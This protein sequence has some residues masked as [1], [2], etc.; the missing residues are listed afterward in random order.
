M[1]LL[2]LIFSD[3]YDFDVLSKNVK[4]ECLY[5]PDLNFLWFCHSKSWAIKVWRSTCMVK[6][7]MFKWHTMPFIKNNWRKNMMCM[8]NEKTN[9]WIYL[10]RNIF[11]C[12][13][14]RHRACR[15]KQQG[16]KTSTQSPRQNLLDPMGTLLPTY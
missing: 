14:L 7:E 2:L 5:L 1:L 8:L 11:I 3:F 10:S 4:R 12:R 16:W 9:F 13:F 6:F 15:V